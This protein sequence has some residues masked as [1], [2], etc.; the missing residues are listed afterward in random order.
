[1]KGLSALHVDADAMSKESTTEVHKLSSR[2][3]SLRAHGLISASYVPLPLRSL[4]SHPFFDQH[5]F[6]LQTI[7]T[8]D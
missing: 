4:Y 2:A 6:V 8:L 5:T 7:L 3:C 1:M